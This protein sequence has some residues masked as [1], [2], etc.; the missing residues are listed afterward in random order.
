MHRKVRPLH[1]LVSTLGLHATMP[2]L[3][4]T[5]ELLNR[6]LSGVISPVHALHMQKFWL[7]LALNTLVNSLRENT[8]SFGS[9][10]QSAG[11]CAPV[12]P[13]RL[14]TGNVSNYGLQKLYSSRCSSPSLDHLVPY[15]TTLHYNLLYN[16]Y[17]YNDYVYAT[18]GTNTTNNN[19]LRVEVI[20]TLQQ[21]PTSLR[22]G[23]VIAKT[24]LSKTILWTGM[25][26]NKREQIGVAP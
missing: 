12:Q 11:T 19:L 2:S 25:A 16:N 14:D 22:D 20:L 18:L 8:L 1:L 10:P 7:H 17:T 4:K 24:S 26:E 3:W 21:P 23:A 13:K 6:T 15:G 9:L 5:S